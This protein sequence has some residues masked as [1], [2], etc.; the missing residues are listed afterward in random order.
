[1]KS[2]FCAAD[3]LLPACESDMRLWPALACDQFTSNLDYWQK[4]EDLVQDVPSTLHITLPEAYLETPEVPARIEA[5]HNAMRTYL[6]NVLTRALHGFVYV[7]RETA[8]GIRQGLVG[9]VDLEAYSYQ[10]QDA[11]LIRPSENT[12]VERIP[13]RLAMR[14]GAALETPHIMML[15]DDNARRL[16][17]PFAQEKARLAPLYNTPLMLGGGHVR[18]WAVTDAA[19]IQRIEEAVASFG[20]QAVFDAQ[21]PQA[22]GAPP[23]AMAVGD[24]NHSLATA[25][26]YWEE[27]KT[28]LTLAQQASHPARWCLVELV[29]I[30]SPALAIEPIHRV[31]FGV[32][33]A[34]LAAQFT[35]FMRNSHTALTRAGKAQEFVFVGDG[36]ERKICAAHAP[37]P[38]AVGTLELFLDQLCKTLPGLR[39]DYIHGE[40]DVRALAQ[41]GAAGV[42]LPPFAK[43]DLFQGIVMGGVLPR[44][45][46]SMGEAVE[47]RYYLECRRIAP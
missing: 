6:N 10:R 28:G 46:F 22:A 35:A 24:G 25:K 27:C 18:G 44:K 43:S 38:L 26:A 9:A 13:P 31:V 30:H 34:A 8:S 4:A 36:F 29:N 14:R 42:I 37:A 17:E 47:K 19:D 1:M 2:V 5:A 33:G 11:P 45:T 15:I 20:A 32:E 39:I 41:K 3:I 16:I 40:A 23:I 21:Y 7:E 12:V